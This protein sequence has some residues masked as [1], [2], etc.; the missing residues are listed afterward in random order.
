MSDDDQL[1]FLLLNQ[2]GDGV[3]TGANKAGLLLGLDIL[4][5]SLSFSN[6]LQALLLGNG[7]FRAVFLQQLE[8][9]DGGGFVKSLAELVDWWRNLQA[10]LQNSLLALHTDVL[11]P[12]DETGQVTFGLDVLA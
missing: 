9:L 4:A 7:G 11:G 8:H 12:F 10:L 3:C 1:S 2:F 5:L 6:L